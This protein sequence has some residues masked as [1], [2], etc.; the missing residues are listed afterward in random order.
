MFS[1]KSL[2]GV[3]WWFWDL[4][5]LLVEGKRET[6]LS[7]TTPSHHMRVTRVWRVSRVSPVSRVSRNEVTCE[8]AASEVFLASP[9]EG[10]AAKVL[11]VRG[12]PRTDATESKERARRYGE[13]LGVLFFTA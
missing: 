11:H 13:A 10:K 12:S 7:Q 8:D 6:T 1:K 4:R 3:A 5:A 9:L 2:V